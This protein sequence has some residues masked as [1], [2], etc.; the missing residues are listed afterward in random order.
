[1]TSETRVPTARVSFPDRAILCG[2]PPGEDLSISGAVLEADGWIVHARAGFDAAR[3]GP[4]LPRRLREDRGVPQA[5]PAS[6]HFADLAT[7]LSRVSWR[8]VADV[9]CARASG[10]FECGGRASFG[11]VPS[12]SWSVEDGRAFARLVD[13]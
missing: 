4:W 6:G 7:T 3:L 9:A 12:W 2:V 5:P 8:L 11:A 10:C 13:V 1:M